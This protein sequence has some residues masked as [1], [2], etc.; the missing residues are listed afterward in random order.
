MLD[1]ILL[2][3]RNNMSAIDWNSRGAYHLLERNGHQ[4]DSRLSGG[5]VEPGTSWWISMGPQSTLAFFS[6]CAILPLFEEQ[7][8][9]LTLHVVRMLI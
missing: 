6:S 9:Y 7:C 1:Q 3:S 4:N 5:Q 8:T 2:A